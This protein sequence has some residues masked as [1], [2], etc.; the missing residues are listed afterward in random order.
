MGSQN[1]LHVSQIDKR[2]GVDH[3]PL[4]K[5]RC[6]LK[7]NSLKWKIG[8][9]RFCIFSPYTIKSTISTKVSTSRKWTCSLL[10]TKWMHNVI[11]IYTTKIIINLSCFFLMLKSWQTLQNI[12]SSAICRWLG[13][14]C[15][16]EQ[17]FSRVWACFLF[18][19]FNGVSK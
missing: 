19:F 4:I 10:L 6:V 8:R 17:M 9:I 3:L 12:F 14:E 16:V 2:G 7:Q 11:A 15:F 5:W 13:M 18:S 1:E